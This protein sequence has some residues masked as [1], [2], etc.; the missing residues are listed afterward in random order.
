MSCASDRCGCSAHS[1]SGSGAART[2]PAAASAGTTAA[3]H[4]QGRNRRDRQALP[5]A[6]HIAASVGLSWE[7]ARRPVRQHSARAGSTLRR[8]EPSQTDSR[9]PDA[10]CPNGCGNLKPAR[11]RS[12][13]H[14]SGPSI[15]A[16]RP[17][18]LVDVVIVSYNSA[19]CLARCV[20]PLAGVEWAHIVVV[21]NA[22]T[23]ASLDVLRD[24]PVRTIALGRNG[25]FAHGCNVGWRAG[26]APYVLFVN[27]DARIDPASLE[28]L[29]QVLRAEPHVGVVAPRIL[30]EDGSVAWSQRR[31]PRPGSTLA[32]A[33]FLH[34]VLGKAGWT[35]EL[36]R[37]PGVYERLGEPDWVS[38]ACLAMRRADLELLGGFD[39]R[40]FMYREDIDLCK[41]VRAAGF[42]VRF[43]PTAVV[44]H[45]G[46]ASAPQSR[47]IPVLAT[48]RLRYA[49]KHYG[50]GG[51]LLERAAVA[52]HA[53]THALA[54]RGGPSVRAGHA[55]ALA[56]AARSTPRV[57][58]R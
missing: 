23:D 12:L 20:E 9:I 49:E 24:L 31:F 18:E 2:S 25:G 43:E 53:L 33:L 47:Q 37:D 50:R 17:R 38:G 41:R 14:M 3:A 5:S 26:D 56:A 40:F 21:D 51:A 16:R 54:G 30:E 27:P 11:L 32:Q 42:S 58:A 39:E 1:S 36:V 8:S 48:S 57:V 44:V 52:L 55:R 45:E 13:P 34:R 46:G 29:V 15:T 28:G 4:T 35:D 10:V 22:S 6:R 7:V 19:D